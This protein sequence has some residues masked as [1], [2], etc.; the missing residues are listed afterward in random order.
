MKQNSLT[1]GFEKFRKKTRKERF[2]DDMETII[3]WKELCEAIIPYY[4]KQWDG[5]LLTLVIRRHCAR[6]VSVNYPFRG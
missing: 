4:R 2:L 1:D 3:P 6:M 5:L